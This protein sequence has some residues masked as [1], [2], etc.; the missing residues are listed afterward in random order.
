[1]M[2][3]NCFAGIID[4]RTGAVIPGT[5]NVTPGMNMLLNGYKLQYAELSNLDLTGSTFANAD[6]SFAD[7]SNSTLSGPGLDPTLVNVDFAGANLTDANLS[8]VNSD[9]L[10]LQVGMNFQ[11]TISI[12]TDFTSA[13][14][15]GA[16]FTGSLVQDSFFDNAD[17]TD[18]TG[19]VITTTPEP[20]TLW[21]LPAFALC[22]A[23][24]RKAAAAVSRAF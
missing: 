19:L 9:A 7:L 18:V 16:D 6:L 3:G 8:F 24:R 22:I 21:L 14:L 1:M 17:L 11:N 15:F 12:N 5:E 20:G 10:V 23:R 2:V 4:Y 13:E